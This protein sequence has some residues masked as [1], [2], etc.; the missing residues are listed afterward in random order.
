V[1]E[2]AIQFKADKTTAGRIGVVDIGSNTLRLVI[3]DVPDRMPVPMF[4]EKADCRLV[5]GLAQTGHLSP[6]GVERA[7]ASLHR[8]IGLAD[9]MGADTIDLLATAAVREANDGKDFVRNIEDTFGLKVQVLSGNEEAALSAL[10][11]VA[12]VPDADGI[13]GDLGG[14]S[15][16]MVSL[17]NGEAVEYGTTQLGHVR[18][19]EMSG[20]KRRRAE[21]I[22]DKAFADLGWL[23][24]YTGKNLYLAGGVT[25]AVARIFIEQT[26]YPLHVVDNYAVRRDEALML[27]KLLGGL[28]ASTLKKMPSVSQSRAK[29]IP[30]A[31]MVIGKMIETI[32]PKSVVF[33]GFGMRE[34]QMMM[35][36]LPEI[37]HQD[38]LIAGAE[39]LAERTGR[40]S[41]TGQEIADWLIPMFPDM[42]DA[43]KRRTLAACLLSDIGWSEHPDYRAEHAFY[44]CLRLPYAGLSHADRVFVATTV[45]VRYNG[46]YGAP[47]VSSVRGLLEEEQLQKVDGIGRAIRLAHTLSGSAPGILGHTKLERKAKTLL[48]HLPGDS[49]VFQSETVERRFRGLKKSLGLRGSI[50]FK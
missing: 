29:S 15:L 26:N 9:L 25:R 23:K 21:D 48:L 8:F 4:N 1:P 17:Q 38:P 10:G 27:S 24:N 16:D 14:G 6:R 42:S 12:G 50:V 43:D 35:R 45:Y 11:L 20:G 7:M 30:F 39:T 44:R 37:R 49:R 3:Y 28:S 41:L 19:R 36:L 40:F 18:L 5:E 31:A 33:S 32:K 13:L 22:I 2:R 47:L 46:D 34:G